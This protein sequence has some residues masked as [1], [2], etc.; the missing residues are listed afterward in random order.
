MKNYIS[1]KSVL[2]LLLL[3]C[4]NTIAVGQG[5]AT[6]PV[7]TLT[8][9][10]P[11][12]CP[13]Q[14]T[15]VHADC[16][17]C[18][19]YD[20]DP[21]L[22]WAPTDD[23]NS[24]EVYPPNSNYYNVTGYDADG[25]STTTQIFITVKELPAVMAFDHDICLGD[26]TEIRIFFL[27]DPSRFDWTWTSETPHHK[28]EYFEV[29]P[30]ETTTYTASVMDLV[31]KCSSVLSSTVTVHKYPEVKVIGGPQTICSGETTKDIPLIITPRGEPYNYNWVNEN[32][33]VV[34]WTVTPNSVLETFK[35]LYEYCKTIVI[36]SG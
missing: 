15:I 7:I 8:A 6:P 3:I 20:W 5:C 11:E 35:L 23:I 2:L 34:R 28:L 26:K 25:C 14:T 22:V 36:I 4:G 10:E 12:V 21:M 29:A 13:T 9:N 17:T 19:S 30:T 1:Y 16:P 33:I 27:K 18:V 31:T 32:N 24:V